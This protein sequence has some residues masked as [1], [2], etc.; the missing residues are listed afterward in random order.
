MNKNNSSSYSSFED[1]LIAIG[2]TPRPKKTKNKEK[3]KKQQDHLTGVCRACK[4]PLTWIDGTNIVSCQNPGCRG[5]KRTRTNSE[6]G[7]KEI[8]YLP[9]YRILDDR[10]LNIA[11][12]LFEEN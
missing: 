8:Y 2:G 7:K 12:N 11:I 6:T 10:G 3:L 9:V 4:Q 1:A 5:L